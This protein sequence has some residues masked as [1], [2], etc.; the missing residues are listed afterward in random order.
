MMMIGGALFESPVGEGNGRRGL[1]D[2]GY[3]SQV[4]PIP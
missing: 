3:T 1:V 4:L 2:S